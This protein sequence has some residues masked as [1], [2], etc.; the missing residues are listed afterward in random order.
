MTATA[1]KGTAVDIPVTT[2]ATDEEAAAFKLDPHLV[3]LMW[4][5][6]LYT[7]PSPRD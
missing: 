5:C 1:K 7:S 4:A 6:L 3:A 2:T